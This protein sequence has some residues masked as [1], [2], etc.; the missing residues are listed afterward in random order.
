MYKNGFFIVSPT[1][2]SEKDCGNDTAIYMK[3]ISELSES[4][5]EAI[6]R[7]LKITANICEEFKKISRADPDRH[8]RAEEKPEDYHIQDSDPIDPG[9]DADIE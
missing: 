9:E 3:L 8:S 5:W 6:Y 2:F 4:R 1:P 7:G